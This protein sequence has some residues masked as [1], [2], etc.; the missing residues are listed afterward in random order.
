MDSVKEMLKIAT[1]T[2]LLLR[3][4]KIAAYGFTLL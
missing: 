4:N 2:S 1:V 3:W